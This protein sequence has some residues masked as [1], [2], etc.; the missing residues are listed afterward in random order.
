MQ[1][2]WAGGG[3]EESF[4]LD[5]L[6]NTIVLV[7][8]VA[9]LAGKGIKQSLQDRADQ[10]GHEIQEA[11]NVYAQ[12]EEVLARYQTMMN[13][14]ETEREQM[15][16]SYRQQGEQEKA[17]LIADGERLAQKI[18]ADAKHSIQN[19]LSAMQRKIENDLLTASLAKAEDLLKAKVNATDHSRLTQDYLT[20]LEKRSP[21][22]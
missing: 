15:L 22:A 19:E 7:G 20:Q 14:F 1:S 16:V 2:I 3:G 5:H 4:V 6:I 21:S 10:I 11:Q 17:D 8:L 9:F 18:K 12:A 13:D